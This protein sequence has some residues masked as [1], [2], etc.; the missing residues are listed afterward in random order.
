LVKSF[1]LVPRSLDDGRGP[2]KIEVWF[3]LHSITDEWDDHWPHICSFSLRPTLQQA[4][5]WEKK[6][7]GNSG[8]LMVLLVAVQSYWLNWDSVVVLLI[9]II[10]ANHW[11]KT[12][13]LMIFQEKNRRQV[14]L[15]IKRLH[16]GALLMCKHA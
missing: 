6:S 5:C 4:R 10:F 3:S 14:T 2:R 8:L 15:S 1:K 13:S 7:L 11:Q 12:K 16:Q 9:A